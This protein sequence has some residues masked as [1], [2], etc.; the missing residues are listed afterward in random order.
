MQQLL[1]ERLVHRGAES[2]LHVSNHPHQIQPQQV[3]LSSWLVGRNSSE[4][5]QGKSAAAK[6]N[7]G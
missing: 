5:A 6:A 4:Q 7:R 1:R 2:S 3:K